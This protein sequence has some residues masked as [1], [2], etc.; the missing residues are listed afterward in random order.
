MKGASKQNRRTRKKRW[1]M[2]KC[3]IFKC[4]ASAFSISLFWFGYSLNPKQRWQWLMIQGIHL[5]SEYMVVIIQNDMITHVEPLGVPLGRYHFLINSHIWELSHQQHYESLLY[6]IREQHTY[7][8]IYTHICFE[9]D[10]ISSHSILRFRYSNI[11]AS[12]V[13]CL[14]FRGKRKNT[15][16]R[17]L[18]SH[19]G[20]LAM[21]Q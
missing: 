9:L 11:V 14:K 10:E 15:C 7:R 4:M 21:I 18:R 19:R 2:R 5:Q 17:R 3:Y 16:Q 13:F 20:V 6:K 1:S 12:W 8:Y